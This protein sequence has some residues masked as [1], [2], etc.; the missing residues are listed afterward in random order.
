MNIDPNV[1]IPDIFN[2]L[3]PST[4]YKNR[5]QNESVLI[6]SD[7]DFDKAAF[8]AGHQLQK[9]KLMDQKKTARRAGLTNGIN[10]SW[11]EHIDG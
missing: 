1:K 7:S 9:Q 5:Q 6:S 2:T 11:F 8:E 10:K 4:N 3:Q